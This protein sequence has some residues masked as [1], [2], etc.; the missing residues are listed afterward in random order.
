M[1]SI[2]QAKLWICFFCTLCLKRKCLICL[3]HQ[4]RNLLTSADINRSS[5]VC[6]FDTFNGAHN[7]TNF[8]FKWE[9]ITEF[10]LANGT[11]DVS[12]IVMVQKFAS[13]CRFTCYR[14]VGWFGTFCRIFG[15]C[16]TYV[17]IIWNGS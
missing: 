12:K 3:I 1:K 16:N 10:S 9:V 17:T 7:A 5:F 13:S 4:E 8:V 14:S 6:T 15:T 11:N 2:S